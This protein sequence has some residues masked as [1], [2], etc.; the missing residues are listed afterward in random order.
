MSGY[1]IVCLSAG[2]SL[3]YLLYGSLL[4]NICIPST[5]FTVDFNFGVI[6]AM[7]FWCHVFCLNFVPYYGCLIFFAVP[8][9]CF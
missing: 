3:I 2:G 6:G 7:Y 4:L 1:S 9:S 8:F 5:W